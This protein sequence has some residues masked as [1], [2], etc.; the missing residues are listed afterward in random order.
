MSE[1][2]SFVSP[3]PTGMNLDT[4]GLDGKGFLRDRSTCC[5]ARERELVF[6][7]CDPQSRHILAQR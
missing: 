1:N 3:H 7:V 5:L 6:A 2:A 4:T